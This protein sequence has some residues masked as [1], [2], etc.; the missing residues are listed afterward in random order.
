VKNKKTAEG[1]S[2]QGSHL[3]SLTATLTPKAT[4][5]L[6]LLVEES[7]NHLGRKVSASSIV[8][9]LL[10][11]ASAQE[12]SWRNDC[13]FTLVK[14]ELSE[15]LVWGKKRERRLP[16]GPLTDDQRKVFAELKEL[17]TKGMVRGKR[18]TKRKS[19][20]TTFP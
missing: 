17:M 19:F 8:R 6:Q 12:S 5:A 20:V 4:N 13:I 11:Y 2:L 1:E 9:A 15:G 16:S 7:R 18:R 10:I 14:E 3:S